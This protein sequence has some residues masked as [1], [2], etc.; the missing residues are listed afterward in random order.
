MST[1]NAPTSSNELAVGARPSLRQEAESSY[2]STLSQR[3]PDVTPLSPQAT[4]QML[5]ELH[6][7]EIELEMQNEE[8]RQAQNKLDQE[9]ARY[10]ALYDL[11]PVGYLALDAAGLIQQTNLK[12]ANL[13][14]LV[15]GALMR[16]PFT[17]FI[18]HDD[19]DHFY[20]LKNTLTDAAELRSCD[21]RLKNPDGTHFWA[22]LDASLTQDDSGAPTLLL[23]LNDISERKLAEQQLIDGQTLLRESAEH[24][25]IILDNML[26]GVIT[27]N[28]LGLIQSFN[29]AASQIFGYSEHEV[30]GHNVSLLMPEPHRGQHDDYLQHHQR[31]GM[32]R[33]MG[34]AREIEGLRQDGSLVQLTLSVSKVTHQGQPLFIGLVRDNTQQHHAVEEIRQLAFFDPLTGLPNRRLLL[35]RLSHAIATSGR[36]G[37]HGALMFLDLDHFKRLNDSLGHDYGDLLLQR[38]STRLQACAREGDTVARIGGD[39]FVLL[40]EGLSQHA[41]EA[42]VQAEAL[43][44]KIIQVMGQPYSLHGFSHNSTPSIGIAVFMA[45]RETMEEL[46]KKSDAAMYQAK[47]GGRNTFRFFDPAMQAAAADHAELETDLRTGLDQ[48]QFLLLY[49]I[50]VNQLGAPI[51]AEA[52]VRWQHPTRGRV[53]P[54]HFIPLAEESGLILPLGQ[55]VLDTACA[56]LRA[57]AGQPATAHWTM[58]VNVSAL[59]FAQADFVEAVTQTVQ[60]SGVNP[61]LLKLELTESMLVG[62]V[63]DVISKMC[64]L[65]AVG[66]C[67]SLDDFGTGYSS[68]SYLGRLPLNQ[69]KIDQ[70]FVTDLQ[71]DSNN[72]VIARAIVALGHSLN[73]KVIAEGVETIEQRDLL[74]AYGCDA[75]QGYYFGRPMPASELGVFIR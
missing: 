14:G 44:N 74:A 12:A 50:Q 39:E 3:V 28:A 51:G 75:F 45:N 20:L 4:Q 13:L 53:S 1:P 6:V 7:H 67:F 10:F 35:D 23:V 11:A 15:R 34:Q 38:V 65:K 21:L 27:L 68:L 29:L 25:Q 69:L 52:L 36:T 47:A 19:Q 41:P 16:Q 31:T 61:A 64:A 5:H 9:R 59:Q 48:Q 2:Q 66:V 37:L 58:A 17:K 54:A 57:W 30:R 70:S 63:P 43:A 46:L 55:W 62:N 18:A 71:I 72:A 33:I 56:Q 8:L 32:T 73:M 49:Q 60:R 40:L 22:H 24:N 26:D 42:A